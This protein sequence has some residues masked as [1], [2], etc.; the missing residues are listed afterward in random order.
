MIIPEIRTVQA[1]RHGALQQHTEV[2]TMSLNV[3]DPHH[4]STLEFERLMLKG[5]G[6]LNLCLELDKNLCV[7]GFIDA[8]LERGGEYLQ[9]VEAMR[10]HIDTELRAARGRQRDL[11]LDL[12]RYIEQ[13]LESAHEAQPDVAA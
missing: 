7:K 11:L 3:T 13:T 12:Y 1:A 6:L 9:V 4:S 5:K 2:D 8:Q 10:D